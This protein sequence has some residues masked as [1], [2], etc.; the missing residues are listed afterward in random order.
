MSSNE[1]LNITETEPVTLVKDF[2]AFTGYL[3]KNK[4]SLVRKDHAL[5]REAL[6]EIEQLMSHPDPESTPKTLLIFYPHLYL[7]Y[8][9]ALGGALF[10]K[11]RQLKLQETE[12]LTEYEQLNPAEKYFFL[13]ETLWVDLDWSE[14]LGEPTSLLL[15]PDAQSLLE[16]LSKVRPG[17]SVSMDDLEMLDISF[18]K[19]LFL[20]YLSCFGLVEVTF[21]KQETK[22][23]GRRFHPAASVTVTDFGSAL[24]PI[25]CSERN[26]EQWNLPYI[27]ERTGEYILLS[28]LESQKGHEPFCKPF[29]RLF[30]T[31]QKTL[32]RKRGHESTFLFKVFSSRFVWRTLLLSGEHTLDDLHDSIQDAFDFD[33]DHLYGFFMDGIPWSRNSIWGPGN[34]EGP[35][36]DKV[37][38]CELGLQPGQRFVY[39]FDFGDEWLFGIELLKITDEKG[40][41]SPKIVEKKGKAPK[42]YGD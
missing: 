31:L 30:G 2:N 38:I 33:K 11:T 40:P 42:Q 36:A 22:T 28:G 26:L 15:I 35:Y 27:R 6:Y 41:S 25:L 24:L 10:L 9:I 4:P 3:K 14:L 34:D 16:Y 1:T 37:Q 23:K 18:S 21:E 17:K 5:T 13:L 12:K 39:L 7:F 20:Q 19:T 32:P 8:S 29:Q